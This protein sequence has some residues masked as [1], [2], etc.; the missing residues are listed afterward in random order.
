M[1]CS[2]LKVVG[3]AAGLHAAAN[4]I[5]TRTLFLQIEDALRKADT[6]RPRRWPT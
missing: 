5:P 2:K 6:T 4:R 3:V 1:K